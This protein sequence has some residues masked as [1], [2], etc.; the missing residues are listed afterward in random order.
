MLNRLASIMKTDIT[1]LDLVS[2]MK[3]D[4]TQLNT[5]MFSTEQTSKQTIAESIIS[6]HNQSLED[7]R[8]FGA[9]ANTLSNANHHK[10]DDQEFEFYLKLISSLADGGEYQSLGNSAELLR[11][12]I[13]AKDSFLKIEQ[14][15]L[16]YRSLK[17]QDYYDFVFQLLEE[18]FSVDDSD[19]LAANNLEESSFTSRKPQKKYSPEEFQLKIDK[20][21]QQ[22]IASI[23]TEQGKKVLQEYKES[24]EILAKEKEL[25]LK[26]LY[27]FKKFRAADLS[28]LKVISDMVEY[29]QNKNIT[30]M[31]LS[32]DLAKNNFNV[33]EQLREIIGISKQKNQPDTYGIIL[34]YI[35]LSKK[36]Q[37]SYFQ[38]SKMLEA[39]KQWKKSYETI[40][41]IRQ[42]H[43]PHQYALPKE[44]TQ[45][46]IGL[47]TYKKYQYYVHS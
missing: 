42:G 6:L 31:S 16:R 18:N 37:T 14:T 24:I 30:N 38:F 11:V 45:E 46:I 44:F 25:G 34:Q 12:A 23:K 22:I 21:L 35:A 33:F 40:S 39:L 17:Q 41:S 13:Q 1:Q 7:L 2:I 29:L 9:I 15:E 32:L 27:L 36:Y 26:L 4:I 8:V 47:K 43:P 28:A 20:Y 10:F 5:D 19:N 3:T